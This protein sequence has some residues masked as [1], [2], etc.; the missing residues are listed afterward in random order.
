MISSARL[1]F[2]SAISF[3]GE[4][5]S[6]QTFAGFHPARHHEISPLIQG[7]VV[8]GLMLA[9]NHI[10]KS[11]HDLLLY[12]VSQSRLDANRGLHQHIKVGG[13]G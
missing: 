8:S 11:F 3:A 4:K 5:P 2:R 12:A 7:H 1:I 13:G 6:F 9:T 10:R